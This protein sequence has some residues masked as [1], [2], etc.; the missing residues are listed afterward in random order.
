[1]DPLGAPGQLPPTARFSR[2]WKGRSKGA[3]SLLGAEPLNHV[4][5][6][7]WKYCV[8]STY[9]LISSGSHSIA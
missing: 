2:K 8:P 3:R 4:P 6:V 5:L 9:H 7:T 1:M